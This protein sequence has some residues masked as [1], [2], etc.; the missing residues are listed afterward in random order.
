MTADSWCYT[1]ES[2][3]YG[4]RRVLTRQTRLNFVVYL[5]FRCLHSQNTCYH[6]LTTLQRAQSALW[7]IFH[8][9]SRGKSKDLS[10]RTHR[11]NITC[12]IWTIMLGICQAD[13]PSQSW[14][15]SRGPPRAECSWLPHHPFGHNPQ[16]STS[17][18]L[19]YLL[20]SHLHLLSQ[21][22]ISFWTVYRGLL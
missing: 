21:V 8:L 17:L 18:F 13:I 19:P 5:H 7:N 10:Q 9:E 14:I 6:A 3:K 2:L 22:W 15:F 11:G 1:E 12:L 20:V 4:V 16:V